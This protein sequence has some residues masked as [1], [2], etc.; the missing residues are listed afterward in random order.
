MRILHICGSFE[1]GGVTA[2]VKN[3]L[4]L[5]SE[6]VSTHDLMV[7]H[8]SNEVEAPGGATI[9]NMTRDLS[10]FKAGTFYSIFSQYEGIIIHKAHPALLIPLMRCAA[11]KLIFQHGMTMSKGGA[12][13]KAIKGTWYSQLPRLLKAK[14]VCS[15]QY[16]LEKARLSGIEIADSDA[17]ITPFGIDLKRKE[18]PKEY[19][20][21]LKSRLVVGT[22]GRLEEIKRFGLLLQSLMN[23]SGRPIELRIAGEGN[24]RGEL[25]ALAAKLPTAHVQVQ[26]TGN[27]SDLIPFYDDLDIFVFP[28]HNESFGLVV[29]EALARNIPV[30]VFPDIGG[31]LEVM[32]DEKNGFV[33]KPGKEG[34]KEL[35]DKLDNNPEILSTMSQYICNTDLSVYNIIA[36]RKTMDNLIRKMKLS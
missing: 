12:L 23:Y 34:L 9:Y 3:M 2:F 13:K 10:F 25:E 20:A 28:S 11:S 29:V 17:F 5:N 32:E 22:A 24:L 8:E 36:T 27:L 14:V 31:A 16:A 35:W 4:V 26:F 19:G 15:T 7:I 1:K 18:T 33:M 6:F 30:A 21:P